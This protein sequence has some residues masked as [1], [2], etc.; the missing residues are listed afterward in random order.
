MD[1]I[2][3]ENSTTK[4]PF[5]GGGNYGYWKAHMAVFL[6]SLDMRSWRAIISGWENPIE[7][8]E[9]E[10]ETIAKFNVRVLDITNESNAL[11]EDV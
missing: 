7:K 4:A 3:E 2:R 6:M 8:D 9:T 10:D 1:G 5:L 11:G